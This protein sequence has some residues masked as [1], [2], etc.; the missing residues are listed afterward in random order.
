MKTLETIY[1]LKFALGI[2]AALVCTG[3]GLA[4]GTIVKEG[5]TYTA[6]LNGLSIALVIY[7][8]SYYIIKSKF[9]LKVEKPQKLLTTGIGVYFISWIVFW[10]LLYTIVAATIA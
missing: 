2:T 1:W 6:L 8:V 3:Y 10:V 9:S 5:F 4:T 7:L